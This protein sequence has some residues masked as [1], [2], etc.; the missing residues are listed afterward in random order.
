MTNMMMLML[1]VNVN[2]GVHILF[3][4]N[5][6]I[7]LVRSAFVQFLQFPLSQGDLYL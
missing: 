4:N 2:T 5:A 7:L 1:S 3:V 6:S